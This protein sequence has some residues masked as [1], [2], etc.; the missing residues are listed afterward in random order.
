MPAFDV[1][2]PRF[3]ADLPNCL[4]AI[5]SR[6][7]PA[8][9]AIVIAS[10]VSEFVNQA[11]DSLLRY[12]GGDFGRRPWCDLVPFASSAGYDASAFGGAGASVLT[13][14]QPYTTNG[15]IN[16]N[17]ISE[18]ANGYTF[19]STASWASTSNGFVAADS[20]GGLGIFATLGTFLKWSD[21]GG[22]H[23]AGVAVTGAQYHTVRLGGATQPHFLDWRVNGADQFSSNTYTPT[24]IGLHA[25]S[26]KIFSDGSGNHLLGSFGRF[27]LFDR[28]LTDL[29]TDFIESQA[30]A[31]FGLPPPS[32]RQYV[33]PSTAPWLDPDGEG[34][35][36]R[37][38]SVVGHAPQ[39]LR[40]KR[41]PGQRACVLVVPTISGTVDGSMDFKP[42][43]VEWPF[44]GYA[45]EPT[46]YQDAV[47]PGVCRIEFASDGHHL[48]Q[49]WRPSGGGVLVHVDV[50]SS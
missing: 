38:N 3:A 31:T 20:F 42:W 26:L 13:V 33:L 21:A 32:T 43:F 45:P 8:G 30:A 5:D 15:P 9:D 6:S 40:V 17:G 35:T 34:K 24:A 22:F 19:F 39:Y 7:Q 44:Q 14:D 37:I 27:S 47:C 12:R 1:R 25:G 50:S 28:A 48:F 10:S 36:S 29:E 49:L 2:F 11:P 16:A 23:N 18:T 4:V 41:L 46:V